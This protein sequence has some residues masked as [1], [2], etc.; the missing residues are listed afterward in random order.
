M[1]IFEVILGAAV[2][3]FTSLVP[4]SAS[5][6]ALVMGM[7][8][9]TGIDPDLTLPALHAG[10]LF[11]LCGIARKNLVAM[12]SGGIRA[13]SRP[14]LLQSSPGAQDA[15]VVALATAVS[16][17]SM[18]LLGPL[19]ASWDR[20]PM[21]VGLGLLANAI[22]LGSTAMAP[23]GEADRPT[24]W[25]AALVGAASAFALAPGQSAIG[26]SLAAL[27]WLGV[28]AER[29]LELAL[30]VVAPIVF[31]QAGVSVAAGARAGLWSGQLGLSAVAM[32]TA[33]GGGV[34][35]YAAL[36]QIVARAR[37]AS[38]A[39]Y[40]VPLGLAILAYA[41]ALDPFG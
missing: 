3:G 8:L 26:L 15:V 32:A 21:A 10:V 27:L 11:A 39:L 38:L 30:C 18:A 37:L 4:V 35:G 25:G 36:R 29:A 2:H 16:I 13:L 40:L 14:L 23:R 19:V 34:A 6:H 33:I 17:V 5:G 9:D 12:A 20:A 31:W 24:L 28:R 41:R 22:A 1:K 7:W